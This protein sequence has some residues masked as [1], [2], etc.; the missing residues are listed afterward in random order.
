MDSADII[1]L[2]MK[3]QIQDIN[4]IKNNSEALAKII[5][6]QLKGGE[7]PRNLKGLYAL[8]T[9]EFQSD[10]LANYPAFS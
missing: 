4:L 7:E 10:I 8:L 1:D 3:G 9:A 6:L 2:Y 5:E